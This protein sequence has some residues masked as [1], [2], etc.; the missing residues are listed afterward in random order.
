MKY[1]PLILLSLLVT[2]C[3]NAQSPNNVIDVSHK[4]ID[5]INVVEGG[6][7]RFPMLIGSD[8][9]SINNALRFDNRNESLNLTMYVLRPP[10]VEY[11]S[12]YI[13]THCNSANNVNETTGFYF[14]LKI[15]TKENTKTCYVIDI[16]PS[17]PYIE[18]LIKWIEIS[19]YKGECKD[20]L[21]N[22]ERVIRYLN[23]Y[24]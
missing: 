9:N 23:K 11:I 6:N 8:S 18:G 13:S 12:K 16:K 20:I 10:I 4:V 14:I 15:Y 3:V 24:K 2:G 21:S 5:I 17:K 7:H 1:I 19:P 22:F